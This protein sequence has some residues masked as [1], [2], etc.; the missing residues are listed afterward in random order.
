MGADSKIE[1]THHT[2][3]C[4]WGCI[5]DGPECDNCYARSF[6]KRTGH[7]VWGLGDR[8][9]FEEK[10]WKEPILWNFRAEEAGERRRV[11]CGSM[12]DIGECRSDEVGYRMD[13]E[14]AKLWDLIERTPWLD[15]LLL[16]KRPQNFPRIL[17][18]HW[19][20]E[21]GGMPANVWLGTTA[22]TREGWEK[23]VKYL[24]KLEP[25]VRFVSVEPMLEDM[26]NVDLTGINWLIVGGESGGGAR[27]M[28]IGWAQTLMMQSR[29]ARI[30]TFFKQ[31]GSRPLRGY[32]AG[33]L[34]KLRDKKGGDRSEI[35][36]DW[37]REFPESPGKR[38]RAT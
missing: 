11:F 19:R 25:V 38:G 32:G 8:R 3:N 31:F 2:F 15:W 14:R 36:G 33:E 26:T 20:H 10:H 9:F 13:R 29:A 1:W 6:A 21:T 37:P 24:R 30:A 5:E 35:P 28:H 23:R 12:M 17:P 22:G 27:S 4:W 16:S 18:L 7:N 34:V